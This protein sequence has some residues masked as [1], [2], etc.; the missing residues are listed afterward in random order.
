MITSSLA[1][2]QSANDSVAC[3]WPTLRSRLL[4]QWHKLSIQELN[5]IGP[6]RHRL[7]LLV[8]AKYGIA[9]QLVENYIRN[10]ERSLPAAA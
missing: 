5:D 2:D 4:A 8:Q 9:W 6:Q 7:A 3:H 10:M 1:I